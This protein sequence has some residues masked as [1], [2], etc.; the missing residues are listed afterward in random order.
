[1]TISDLGLAALQKLNAK[2]KLSARGV[3]DLAKS[4][5]HPLHTHFEWDNEK[6]GDAHRISQA[7]ALIRSVRVDLVIDEKVIK[8]PR[9]VHDP[10][11]D[12]EQGYTET[13]AIERGSDR[14]WA[15]MNAEIDRAASAL[16]RARSVAAGLGLEL[17]FGTAEAE[18]ESLMASAVS[19][20]EAC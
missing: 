14:S 12:P 3:V 18:V 11:K 2:G 13:V 16:K 20:R 6:A 15:V 10:D 9:Y 19:L 8:V 17:N 5:K 7:R 1:M 4:P